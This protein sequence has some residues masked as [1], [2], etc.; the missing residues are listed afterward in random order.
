MRS[1]SLF[2]VSLA[3]CCSSFAHAPSPE[4]VIPNDNRTAAG[5]LR[6]GVLTVHLEAREGLW[7][8]DEDAGPSIALQMFAEV[9]KAP[10]NPGPLIRVPAGTLLRVSVRNSLGDSVLVLHGFRTRPSTLDDTV[11]VAAGATRELEFRAGAPGTYF[12]WG[13]TTHHGASDR[14]G[15][16]SQLHGAFI[17]D[18]AGVRPPPDR[19][20]VL[21]DYSGPADSAGD[22]AELRVINGLS[23]PHT[24]RF[25][26]S[27]GDTV[28]WRWVNPSDSP[29]PMHLHGFYFD[30]A[31]R[32]TWARDSTFA[33]RD[34]SHVVTEMPLS[35][36]TFAMTWVPREP[37]NWLF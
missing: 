28:R 30:V 5:T 26:Y 14:S 15:I 18:P 37:G 25:T 8:P 3:L 23:W 35:G 10:Q 1:L 19:I 2:A 22:N 31:S 32:G 17:V 29:H 34:V 12:Y 27:A 4:R 20:F 11:Q 13:T 16:D 7:F 24:E 21:G 9:G 36:E 6:N 33:R